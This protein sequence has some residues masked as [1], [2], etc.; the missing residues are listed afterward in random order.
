VQH[1]LI[2]LGANLTFLSAILA[3]LADSLDLPH[4]TIVLAVP[5]VSFVI[6]WLYFEQD[7]FLTQAASYLH[8]ALRPNILKRIEHDDPDGT[9]GNIEGIFDWEKYRHNLLFQDSRNRL[10][11]R[12]MI[13]FRLAATVG[14]GA[15]LFGIAIYVVL[16]P[17]W[18]ITKLD[19]VQYMLLSID[20][21][22]LIFC[23]Y[24]YMSV[25]RL[26]SEIGE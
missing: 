23:C 16:L 15:V 21:I 7:V 8:R 20:L 13:G 19:Y 11:M 2:L 3:K 26:Y 10:F 6:C 9:K 5:L 12:L 4:L 25:N 22:G 1:Q 18:A 24:E 14:P 17:P